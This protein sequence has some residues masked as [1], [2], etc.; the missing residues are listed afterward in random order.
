MLLRVNLVPQKPTA[1]RIKRILPLILGGLVLLLCAFFY[2]RVGYI[3]SQIIKSQKEIKR[4]EQTAGVTEMLTSQ[5]AAM[6]SQLAI[7]KE[8]HTALRESV[9]KTEG[10]QAE[11]NYYSI[12]LQD[13]SSSLP[14]SIKCRKI[15]LKGSNGVID[16]VAINHQDI[17]LFIRNLK[18]KGRYSRIEF[19][20]VNKE[21]VK[22]IDRFNFTLILTM[23]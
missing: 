6:E 19:K 12:P 14:T 9:R 4:V 18:D 21:T 7:L 1:E 15:S 16:A 17:P 5:I 22:G 10:I 11:K 20:D 13:I 3:N 8:K 2:L 23:N